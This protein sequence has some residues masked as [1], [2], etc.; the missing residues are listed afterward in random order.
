MNSL[1]DKIKF[2]F[3]TVIEVF[4]KDSKK[5]PIG[6]PDVD[7]EETVYLNLIVQQVRTGL[8]DESHS[9]LKH[10]KLFFFSFS[11]NTR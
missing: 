9:V 10:N 6:D 8:Q 7:W 3:Q 1:E 11:L 5:L 4:R 2:C